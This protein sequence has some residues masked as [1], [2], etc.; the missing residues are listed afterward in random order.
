MIG[1]LDHLQLAWNTAQNYEDLTNYSKHQHTVHSW[2]IMKHHQ[3]QPPLT[4]ANNRYPASLAIKSVIEPSP[5]MIINYD[6][7]L[8]TI[9]EPFS[10]DQFKMSQT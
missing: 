6:A 2:A 5:T 10:N 9:N 7:R 4:H 1:I 3:P 8:S